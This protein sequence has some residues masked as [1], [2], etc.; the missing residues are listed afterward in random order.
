MASWLLYNSLYLFAWHKATKFWIY[1]FFFCISM[2]TWQ[3]FCDMLDGFT[4]SDTMG[5]S[6]F[7]FYFFGGVLFPIFATRVKS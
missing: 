2:L 1:F 5:R 4:R 6:L 7:I 3:I